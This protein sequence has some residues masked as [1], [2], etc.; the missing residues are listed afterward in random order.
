MKI[1]DVKINTDGDFAII[2]AQCRI[3]RAGWDRAYFKFDRKNYYYLQPDASPFAAA[4]LVP[5]MA[6]GEDLVVEGAISERLY[7]GM[8]AIMKIISRWNIGL[9]PVNIIAE[10]LIP[11]Q[12]EPRRIAT[13]FSGGVD[14]FYTYLK[15]KKDFSDR[16]SAFIT[17]NGFD[18]D[19]GNKKL[20]TA[21]KGNVADVARHEGIEVVALESN[22]RELTDP[23]FP[24]SYTH[25]G[26]LAAAGLCLRREFKK[27]YVPS[28][29]GREQ[30]IPWGS[31][32]E[33]DKLWSSEALFFDHDGT[34]A[35]RV[36]KIAW[37]IAK[38][39]LALSY[40]RVCYMNAKGAYNCGRCEKCVRT[41]TS[42]L[43]AGKLAEAK[44][45]PN[46]IYPPDLLAAACV[47]RSVAI[48]HKD[49]L[50]MLRKNNI[51][52]DLQTVIEKG[53][54]SPVDDAGGLL[55][56]AARKIFYWDHM[57]LRGWGRKIKKAV[58]THY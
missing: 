3:R 16:I 57:Y 18:I 1:K 51:A 4:L 5:S 47:K 11:D 32:L 30:Q 27:I 42:L 17:I 55:A 24:W 28:S 31:H 38:S 49:N 19:R 46:R 33:T 20:W 44:T 8:R 34:E 6:L 36:D 23:I 9:K 43:A 52:N 21:A 40:L 48:E 12:A 45:F 54:T 53:V 13:F 58:F 14:S 37:Q 50:E 41:M 35:R 29:L 26:C 7:G 25:G 56:R 10:S 39:P 15:H 22:L 2:S